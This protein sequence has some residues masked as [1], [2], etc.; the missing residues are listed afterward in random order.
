MAVWIEAALNGPWTRARQPLIP[1]T[2]EEIVAEGIAC[3]EA[4]AAIIHLHAFDPATGRQ[5]DDADIYAAIIEGIRQKVDAIVYPTLPFVQSAE[6]FAPGAAEARYRAV[7]GLGERGLL[8]WGVVDPGTINL[9][10]FGEIAEGGLGSVYANPGAHI[11]RGLDLAALHGYVPS[12]A[13]YEPGFL[14][15]GAAMAKAVPGCPAPLYRFM[16]SDVFTY[17][18][19]PAPYALDAYLALLADAAPGAPWMAAGLGVDIRP[20]IPDIV[21][22]GG[23]VRVGLEDAPFG[24]TTGNVARV[25]EAVRLVGAAGGRIAGPAEVREALR[26]AG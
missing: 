25:E 3:A 8:E 15:L 21:A 19:P 22:R 7:E 1:I 12:Y 20:L 26:A 24:T 14:R 6:A 17:G 10:T 2:V 18:F 23:H 4:G 5:R 9:A 13:I 11:R 16:F